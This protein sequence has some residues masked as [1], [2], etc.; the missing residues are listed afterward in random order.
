LRVFYS[1]LF[2]C[3]SLNTFGQDSVAIY[4]NQLTNAID[5]VAAH[6]SIVLVV[7]YSISDSILNLMDTLS[8]TAQWQESPP[9][10][11]ATQAA[12]RIISNPARKHPKWLFIAFVLQLLILIYVKATGLKNFEDSIKAYFNTNLSQQLFREQESAI[13]FSVLLQM[14]NFIISCSVLL[15]LFVDYFFQPNLADSLKIGTVIFLFTATIY[16]LKYLG[17]KVISYIFPF[18]EDI[19]LFRFNYFL[20]QKLLGVLLIPFVYTIAYSPSPYNTYFLLISAIIFLS[21]MLVRSAKGLVIGSAYLRKHMFHFLLYICTF[22]IA[23]V[24]IL[25]KWLQLTGYGQN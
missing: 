15:Y 16:F 3:F 4:T 19:D 12:G 22:E 7:P 14:M 2:F 11:F 23:P 9:S 24:L 13:S 1:I 17:Y 6:D 8:A 20:N 10:I 18:S 5:T 25:V 21:T